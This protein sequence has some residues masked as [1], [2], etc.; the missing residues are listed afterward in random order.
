MAKRK[1]IIDTDTASDDAVALIMALRHADTEILAITT[2]AGNVPLPQATQNALYTVELCGA[3]T[4]VYQGAEEP[5]SRPLRTAQSVHGQDGMGDTGLP[6]SGRV[7]A[8]GD[9]VERLVQIAKQHSQDITLVTLGPL[10]NIALALRANPKFASMVSECIV[11]GGS[12]DGRGNTTPAAEFNIWVDPEAAR[13]VFL[14]DLPVTMVGIDICRNHATFGEDEI[15]TLRHM[16][17]PL[18]DFALGI[19]NTVM[20]VYRARTG[21]AGFGLPD[22]AAMAV[23]LDPSLVL[24]SQHLFVDVET[25]GELTRGETVIDWRGQLG[26]AANC[27]VI[28]EISGAGFRSLL[29]KSLQ[30]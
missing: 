29:E 5:L 25:S 21:Q 17:T 12:A 18:A 9:A 19:Q 16:Q 30:G 6:L 24:A 13:E 7:P 2:V 10:T 27:N 20:D 1:F 8:P 23:A 11:M 26:Q 15:A 3:A 28:T 14:S 4:P 22:P